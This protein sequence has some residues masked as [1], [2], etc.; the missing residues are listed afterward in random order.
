MALALSDNAALERSTGA[1]RKSVPAADIH[2]P[3]NITLR[4]EDR[5]RALFPNPKLVIAML[6]GR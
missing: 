6:G 4:T 5:D 3:T 2:P 1:V